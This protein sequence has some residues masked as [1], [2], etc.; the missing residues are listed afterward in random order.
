VRQRNPDDDV[1]GDEERE[2]EGGVRKGCRGDDVLSGDVDGGEPGCGQETDD[3]EIQELPVAEG[4]AVTFR[5]RSTI[6][7]PKREQL[8][9]AGKV[10]SRRLRA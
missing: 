10:R 5:R 9:D 6:A 1:R 8:K 4:Q 7:A 3:E 2:E